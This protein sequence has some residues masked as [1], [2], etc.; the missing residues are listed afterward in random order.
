MAGRFRQHGVRAVV[1]ANADP[2]IDTT[3]RDKQN[4]IDLRRRRL[5]VRGDRVRQ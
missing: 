2:L 4:S 3:K 1:A 5:C